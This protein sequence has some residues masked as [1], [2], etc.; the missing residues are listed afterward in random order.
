MLAL[1]ARIW[2]GHDYVPQVWDDW[3]LDSIGRLMVAEMQ[4]RIVG[5]GKLTCLAPDQWWV[6]GLRVH[7][8]LQ[9]R[10]IASHMHAYLLQSWEQIGSGVLRLATNAK[11]LPIH[12]LCYRT[13]FKQVAEFSAFRAPALHEPV[14]RFSPVTEALLDQA[15]RLAIASPSLALLAGLWDLG[16]EWAAP[17]RIFLARAVERQLAFWWRKDRGLLVLRIDEDED[18]PQSPAPFV[19]ILG[20]SLA[21]LPDLLQ[22]YR[23]L[24][25]GMGF[26]QAGWVAALDPGLQVNLASAGFE[27]TWDSSVYIFEKWD[28]SE[29]E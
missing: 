6:E 7:P 15:L 13:G 27:R 24:A 5:L 20:C 18:D 29:V 26:H 28:H 25:A 9:G 10:G 22:D 21:D 3:L 4:G 23:R 1:T 17:T 12:H 11:R 19:Q 2:D 8:D 16:W 14:D